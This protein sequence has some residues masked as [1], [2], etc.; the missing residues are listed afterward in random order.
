MAPF[1]FLGLLLGDSL[2]WL[3]EV[4]LR[5]F[6]WRSH[7]FDIKTVGFQLFVIAAMLGLYALDGSFDVPRE[8]AD[9]ARSLCMIVFFFTMCAKVV[10]I[11]IR[12]MS[13]VTETVYY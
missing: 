5:V 9:R 7:R 1:L 6:V 12:R 3:G 10:A 13:D 8:E 2:T 4:V 11:S